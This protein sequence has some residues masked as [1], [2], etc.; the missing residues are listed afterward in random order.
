[1]RVIPARRLDVQKAREAHMKPGGM[2]QARRLFDSLSQDI[3]HA[4]RALRRSPGLTALAAAMFALGIGA[5]TVIF[6]VFYA[7]L[8]QPLPFP[9]PERLVQIWE[10]RV[11]RGWTRLS[12][13]EA[14][15]WDVRAYN[16]TFEEIAAF[17]GGDA[18][19]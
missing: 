13:T 10:S 6:S 8:L 11:D 9:E 12:L 7:V 18:N 15:F 19:L 2:E 3:R 5:T 17:L 16:K 1:M 14:N 4:L